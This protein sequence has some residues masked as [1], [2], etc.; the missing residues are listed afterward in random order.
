M[1]QLAYIL[2]GITFYIVSIIII[3][4][5]LNV[6]NNNENKKYK[7]EITTLEREKNLIIS[8]SIISELNKVEALVNNEK[9][10][11]TY[12]DWQKRFKLEHFF[13]FF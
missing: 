1:S 6:I 4:V 12:D 3:V 8:S 13:L 5:V 7:N 9:M 11:E 2:A 10:Q